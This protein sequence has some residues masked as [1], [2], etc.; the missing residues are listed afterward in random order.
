MKKPLK[1]SEKNSLKLL[2]FSLILLLLPIYL[3]GTAQL[4]LRGEEANRILVAYEMHYFGDYF[5]PTHLGKPY[6]LKPPLFNW[7]I[8]LFSDLF[9]WKVETARLVSVVASFLTVLLVYLFVKKLLKNELIALLSAVVLLTLGDLAL[10]Y[11]FLA[12]IDAFHMFLFALLSFV[13]FKLLHEGKIE[14]AFLAAGFLGGLIFL[15]KGFP[16]VYHLPVIVFLLFWYFSRLREFLTTKPFWAIVGASIP[17]GVWLWK[18]KAP[19]VYLKA[20]WRES[21]NRTPLAEKHGFFKHLLVYP[22]LNFRQMMPY[23]LFLP[24]LEIKIFSSLPRETLLLAAL[25]GLNYLPYWVSPGGEGRYILI[26]FPFIAVVLAWG[27]K[28]FLLKELNGKLSLLPAFFLLALWGI[29]A[30]LLVLN[31]D[32]FSQY[33]PLWI[34]VMFLPLGFLIFAFSFGSLRKLITFT[35]LLIAILKLGYINYYAPWRA[36][37]YPEREIALTFSKILPKHAVIQ[38]LPQ[39]IDMALCAYLDLFTRG[40]VLKKEGNFFITREEGPF[41]KGEYKILKVYKGWVLGRKE[42]TEQG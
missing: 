41:P 8:I 19:L 37:K 22:L 36:D 35:V 13:V 7:V 40:I 18:V 6:Y 26:V 32:Y 12:E 1:G 17:L 27:L 2:V 31:G 28:N 20:L 15:T 29:C 21:F 34:S 14:L 25:I 42:K 24:K 39:H 23:S 33:S 16:V 10:F 30:F 5:N 4:P 9:G 38:Y 11:G 3:Y